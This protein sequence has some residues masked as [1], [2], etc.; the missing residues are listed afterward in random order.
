M[1]A[2]AHQQLHANA[3]R[4]I[5]ARF[6]AL[7]PADRFPQPAQVLSTS[8]AAMRGCG[9]SAAKTAAIR[10]IALKAAEGIVP[11]RR[12]AARLSNAELIEQAIAR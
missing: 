10:D 9:F 8:D 3:A 7:Y 5:L 11:S 4:A 1:R 2:I 12:T 6:V